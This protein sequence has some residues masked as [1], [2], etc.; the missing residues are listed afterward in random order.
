[1]ILSRLIA[2]GETRAFRNL[3]INK[4]YPVYAGRGAISIH[5]S[6]RRIISLPLAVLV[7]IRSGRNYFL[8]FPC[9]CYVLQPWAR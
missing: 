4:R 6:A 8:P 5:C 2:W 7:G 3:V 1:M 9:R